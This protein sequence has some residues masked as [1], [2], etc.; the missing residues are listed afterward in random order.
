[1]KA[2]LAGGLMNG[3][4]DPQDLVNH[5]IQEGKPVREFVPGRVVVRELVQEFFSQALLVL[6]VLSQLNQSPLVPDDKRQ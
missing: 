5:S 6:R 1:M 4:V 2:Y 3:W